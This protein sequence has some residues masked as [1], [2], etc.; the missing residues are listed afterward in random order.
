MKAQDPGSQRVVEEEEQGQEDEG[1]GLAALAAT[2]FPGCKQ[3]KVQRLV[4]EMAW[5]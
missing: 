4:H 2:M 5:L 3:C 1:Q